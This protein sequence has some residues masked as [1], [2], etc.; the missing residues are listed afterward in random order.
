MM[1]LDA[2]RQRRL[3]KFQKRVG[4]IFKNLSLLNE[5]LIHSS[6]AY[7]CRISTCNERLEF[8]GDVVIT[9]V[10]TEYLFEHYSS[11][12]EGELAR[13]RSAIVNK[14]SLCDVAKRMRIGD[15]LLLGRSEEKGGGRKKDSI[16]ADAF[17]ALMGAVYMDQ[18]MQTAKELILKL[19][20]K[21]LASI[22]VE[23]F[24]DPK[25]RLQEL[26]LQRYK[27]YPKYLVAKEEGPNHSKIFEVKV[28]VQDTLYGEGRGRSKKEA[29]L[30]AA[31][32]A[33]KKLA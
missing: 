11:F 8:L 24:Q 7:E 1:Q 32:D 4:I 15:Y 31:E 2:R 6:Y 13:A 19:F 25:T 14:L 29:S 18:G 22:K 10:V 20:K 12:Q 3:L 27:L 5:A 16:L 9:F 21:K 23:D 17:E 26:T 28:F 33:L 30:K